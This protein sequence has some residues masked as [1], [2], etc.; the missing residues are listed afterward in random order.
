MAMGELWFLHGMTAKWQMG[1]DT[2]AMFFSHEVNLKH[3]HRVLFV[4][5]LILL[6]VLSAVGDLLPRIY[7]LI[8]QN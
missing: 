4:L 6:S 8:L 2:N 5:I 3:G 1:V 7:I